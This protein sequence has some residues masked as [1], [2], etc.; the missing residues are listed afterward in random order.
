VT[1]Q[2]NAAESVA[3]AP[4]EV[5]AVV[6]ANVPS[7]QTGPTAGSARGVSEG[8]SPAN[9][10][11]QF[12][13]RYGDAIVFAPYTETDYANE[14]TI[15]V[16]A[17]RESK[18]WK[19]LP[20]PAGAFIAKL[21]RHTEGPKDGPSFV[22]GDMV[23]G[24]RLKTS[25]KSLC[26][27]GLDIDTGT[28]R[29][30]VDSALAKLGCLAVRYSTHSAYKTK[31]E[32][33]KDRLVKFANGREIDSALVR[34]F[35]LESEQWEANIANS[36][37]YIG[38][39]H[40]EKGIVCV[41]PHPPIPKHR[42]VVLLKDPFVIEQE[43]PTQAEAMRKWAKVPEALARLLGVPF[44]T[45][46]TDP[47]RL[48]YF[49]RHV[50]GRPSDIS[51]FGGPYFDWR[52]LD[53][54]GD[55]YE[56]V[57]A[58]LDKG[59]SKSVTPEGRALGRWSLKRSHGFQIADVIEAHAPDRIRH[60]TGHG[61]EI[62]CPFDEDH[63]NAGDSDDRAC[64]VV[65]ATE[66]PSEWFTITC[67][68]ES[69]RNK[70]N[71]DMLGKMFAYEWFGREVLEDE[72][73]NAILEESEKPEAAKKIEG[74]D[75]ARAEYR[76]AIDALTPDSTDDAVKE[77]LRQCHD[78][79]LTWRSRGRAED[80]IAKNSSTKVATIRAMSGA[81]ASEMKSKA[82]N[83]NQENHGLYIFR[84][85]DD[86]NFDE[87]AKVCVNALLRA[88]T[89]AGLPLF[90]QFDGTPVRLVCRDGRTEFEDM[91]QTDLWT[92]L[93][94]R[95]TFVE[96]SE[97]GDG[98]RKEVPKE[99]AMQVWG[100]AY[101]NMVAAP[102][103]AYAP[104]FT[105]SGAMLAQD[106]YYLDDALALNHLLVL[107]GLHVPPVVEAPTEAAAQ[108]AVKWILDELLC[109]FPFCDTDA[110]GVDRREPSQANALAYIITPFM[111]RMIS[112]RTPLFA[113]TKPQRDSGAT[114]LA[115]L[116]IKLFQGT[117]RGIPMI[118]YSRSE[119]EMEKKIVSGIQDATPHLF[120]D[121]VREFNN[122][123]LIRF[124]TASLIGGRVLGKTY[125]LRKDNTFTWVLT[126]NNPRIGG[127]MHRRTC[128]IR[129]NL[130]APFGAQ[131]EFHHDNFS[132]FLAENRGRAIHHI[133]TM[134]QYWIGNGMEP[135]AKRKLS[136]FEDWGKKVGGVLQACGVQGFLSTPPPVILDTES[137]SEDA[138]LRGLLGKYGAADYESVS[139]LFDWAE[140]CR[141]GIVTG[142]TP[143][144]RQH[145]FTEA[146]RSLIDRTFAVKGENEKKTLYAF[147]AKQ[148][149]VD[150]VMFGIEAT[151]KDA[152]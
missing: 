131:R 95:I 98:P 38:T 78:A 33:K 73:F 96:S 50:Q 68:H 56:R 139:T 62:E 77:A 37:D 34:A 92:E 44:D 106:G 13:Q 74:Q 109:D 72:Q 54:A 31:S 86:F 60:N 81:L 53:L 129:L 51:L 149:D 101:N 63:G 42:V 14:I 107:N 16:G 115:E 143:D 76:K 108:N 135:F 138:F 133:L 88:N 120:F 145:N 99:V 104:I 93:N 125:N 80:E 40:T 48:F 111:R 28:P 141:F 15:T 127:E 35:L 57:V 119:E 148:T 147:R 121:D 9:I 12:G 39:E 97:S 20:M 41:V 30:T 112:G 43:G 91:G 118:N 85:R 103:V 75:R 1:E 52:S 94:E 19:P 102:E 24:Q 4:R 79:G 66:G 144:E 126:G 2:Y 23:A 55:P 25:V 128:W 113:F 45:S 3:S 69:C 8:A 142:K 116:G 122:R 136:G 59:K 10:T 6:A 84:Y 124:L 114:F 123:V 58:D 134:I 89:N 49:P 117:E 146:L 36:A 105:S 87:A 82:E 64:L 29:E 32:F 27:V 83:K 132:D 70:T 11:Y 18:A 22:L 46:C 151:K 67:R 90:T 71:L 21:C 152:A 5:A 26:G 140:G 110:E 61:L 150:G 47:S 100:Q 137:A 7:E 17:K 65:N 130:K